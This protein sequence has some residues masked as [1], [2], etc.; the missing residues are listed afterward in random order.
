MKRAL[1]FSMAALM[2]LSSSVCVYAEGRDEAELRTM[3]SRV[4]SRIEIPVELEEFNYRV[5]TYSPREEYTFTWSTPDDA[6]KYR[7]ISCTICSSVIT[8]YSY[9]DSDFYNSY[10]MDVSLAELSADQLYS[11]AVKAVKKL[12]PTVAG[13]I[14]IEKDSLSV[15]LSSDRATFRLT[16]TKNGIPVDND[17]GSIVLDKNT[18]ELISFNISWHP[19]ASFRS[20]EKIISE[21]KAKDAYA[22]MIDIYPE[23]EIYFDEDSDAYTSRIVYRQKNWGEINAFTGKKSNFVTDGYYGESDDAVTEDSAESETG[24]ANKDYGFTE[25]ELKE[26]T[27]EL[28]YATAEDIIKLMKSDVYMSYNDGMELS[29]SRLYKTEF[30]DTETYVYRAN[31]SAEGSKDA[32]SYEVYNDEEIVWEEDSY[33]YESISIAVNAETGELISYS[34]YNSDMDSSNSFDEAKTKAIAE[35]VAEKYAGDKFGEY[36]YDTGDVSK[37]TNKQGNTTYYGSWYSWDREVNGLDVRGDYITVGFNAHGVLTEYS[38]SYSDVEFASPDSILSEDEIMDIFWQ[39]NDIQLYYLA[40][41]DEKVTK[42]VLVYGTDA[43]VYRDAFTGEPAYSY[44]DTAHSN[45]EAI[46]DKALREK[47]EILEMHGLAVTSGMDKAT[48]AVPAKTYAK[49]LNRISTMG[50]YGQYDI[51]PLSGGKYDA[52]ADITVGDAMVMLTAAECGTAVPSL[53]GIFRSPYTDVKEDDEKLGYYAIA[54]ALLESEDTVLGAA[55]R[56]TYGDMIEMIY[57]YLAD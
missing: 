5:S 22:D 39:D 43:T 15:A 47:A 46:S 16:R 31:F 17:N 18:G 8:S 54:H 49:I 50:L 7:A 19:N 10:G 24:S 2:A 29:Y 53:V 23:Y 4:K 1:S 11:K 52:E 27:K 41:V 13:S 36:T 56:F 26:L 9:A 20:S 44:V 57:A 30:N 37:Y 21:D 28:P 42:T 35:D 51:I 38:I 3:L 45:T 34:Y 40:K 32:V 33:F 12:N 55:D 14:K 25:A 6:E 48:D